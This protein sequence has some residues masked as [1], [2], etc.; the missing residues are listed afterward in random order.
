MDV[1]IKV[2]PAAGATSAGVPAADPLWKFT[3]PFKAPQLDFNRRLPVQF[4]GTPNTFDTGLLPDHL[5]MG[6][7]RTKGQATLRV[8]MT[9]RGTISLLAWLVAWAAIFASTWPRLLWRLEPAGLALVTALNLMVVAV[10][11]LRFR[12][13]QATAARIGTPRA[14]ARYALWAV[15]ALGMYI[16]LAGLFGRLGFYP[17]TGESVLGVAVYWGVDLGLALLAILVFAAC[18]ARGSRIN[19]DH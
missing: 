2:V 10:M 8:M 14:A 12:P 3:K 5:A 16:F 17:F 1:L 18:A 11:T 6:L 19:R 15:A 13:L 9:A 4:R 7:H